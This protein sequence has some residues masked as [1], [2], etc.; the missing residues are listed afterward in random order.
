MKLNGIT[1]KPKHKPKHKPKAK[2]TL[3]PN[4]YCRWESASG[5]GAGITLHRQQ[6][7]A[8]ARAVQLRGYVR[9]VAYLPDGIVHHG[10]WRRV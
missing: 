2:T 10:A 8:V 7:L 9:A 5:N 6:R 4:G 1:A 3:H